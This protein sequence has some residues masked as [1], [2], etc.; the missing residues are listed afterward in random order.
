ML[1]YMGAEVVVCLTFKA[2][3]GKAAGKIERLFSLLFLLSAHALSRRDHLG[4]P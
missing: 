2:A 1:A 4:F 3:A